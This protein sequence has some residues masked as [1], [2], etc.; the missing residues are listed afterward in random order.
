M[1]I[2]I[3]DAA[4]A[5][6]HIYLDEGPQQRIGDWTLVYRQ[7]SPHDGSTI[8]FSGGKCSDAYRAY[9]KNNDMLFVIRGSDRNS[10]WHSNNLK[11][12]VNSNPK[13]L[14]EA[15]WTFFTWKHMHSRANCY[16][17]GHSLGGGLA[18]V[19]AYFLDL[20]FVAF[21]P[22]A[23]RSSWN[24]R[25]NI[26]PTAAVVPKIKPQDFSKGLVLRTQSDPVSKLSGKFI[27]KDI[28]MP[29]SSAPTFGDMPTWGHSMTSIIQGIENRSVRGLWPQADLI[30]HSGPANS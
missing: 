10:D 30:T 21:N 6:D 25:L 22:P 5:C 18:Q 12:G 8:G 3:Y 24:G 28:K 13:K 2:K 16:I 1:S 26:M 11:I 17:A 29:I 4:V 23:M 7:K 20:P 9:S 19:V 27:G 15:Y 14:D